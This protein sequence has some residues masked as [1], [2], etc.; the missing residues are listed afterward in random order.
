MRHFSNRR[1]NRMLITI[2]I[3]M[4]WKSSRFLSP[5]STVLARN[6]APGTLSYTLQDGHG[7]KRTKNKREGKRLHFLSLDLLKSQLPHLHQ[8]IFSHSFVSNVNKTIC[9]WDKTRICNASYSLGPKSYRIYGRRI[10]WLRPFRIRQGKPI[11]RQ[12]YA[13]NAYFD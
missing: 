11:K 2:L 9:S 6:A 4:Q 1:K 7:K 8:G 10:R 3:C 13:I 5:V 12:L